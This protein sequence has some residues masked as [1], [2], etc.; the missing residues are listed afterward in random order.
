MRRL[1]AFVVTCLAAVSCMTE[2]LPDDIGND[3]A[4]TTSVVT[5]VPSVAETK[6]SISLLGDAV[7][8]INVYAFRN[9]ILVD[10]VYASLPSDV[11]L[12]LASGCSYDIY[13]VANMGRRRAPASEDVFVE[14]MQY[15]VSKISDMQGPVPMSCFK[16]N[17]QVGLPAQTMTLEMERMV[18]KLVLS[19]EQSA[20]LKG[21]QIRSARLCQ[22]AS[23]VRPFKW[24]GR[25]GSRAESKTETVDGDY[26]TASDLA[27]LNSGGEVVFYALENCQGVLLPD[28][29]DPFLKEPSMI[30]G[31]QD[32]CTYLE[33][34][35]AF[36]GTGLLGGDVSYR[37]YAGLDD[38]TSFDVPGNACINVK[39]SLTDDGLKAVSWKVDADVYVMEGYARGTVVQGMHGMSE[40]YVGEMVKYQVELS[41]ELLEYIDADVLGCSL[42]FVSSGQISPGLKCTN[43]SAQGCL[44]NVEILCE[45]P[46]SGKLCLYSPDGAPVGVLESAVTVNVPG[47]AVTEYATWL[48]E[49]P[50]ETLTY[51][52]ECEVN[53]SSQKLYV[54]FVDKDGRNLNGC[55]AYGFDNSLFRLRYDGAYASSASNGTSSSGGSGGSGISSD[56][57]PAV[58]GSFALIPGKPGSAAASLTVSCLNDGTDHGG[59]ILLTEIY[60]REK[61]LRLKAS[62]ANWSIS[63]E[64][65]M[66]LGIRPVE[67]ELVDNGWAGYHDTQLSMTV[68]N[69]SNLPLDVSV[70]QLVSTNLAA[71]P[72]DSDYVENNLQLDQIPYMTGAH[73]NGD[74]PFYG[75]SAGFHSERNSMGDEALNLGSKLAFPLTGISTNDIRKAIAYGRKGAGQMMHMVDV[76]MAGRPMLKDDLVLYDKVSDGSGTYD[77]IYYSQDS[78][79]YRGAS[80][81]SDG[82][83]VTSSGKWA[84]DYP[85]ATPLALDR[86]CKRY[87]EDGLTCVEL[88]YASGYDRLSVCTYTGMGSQYGLTLKFAY[89]GTV[90]GYVKTYPNGT[91]SSAQENYCY[92]DLAHEVSGVP[93]RL[94]GQ[95]VWADEGQLKAAMDDVYANSYKDSDRP[96]GANAYMHRAHPVE[97]DIDVKLLVEGEKG[98]ELYPYYVRWEEDQI[99]YYHLQDDVTYKCA[100]NAA[101]SG[102]S[103]TLVKHK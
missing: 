20:L 87:E 9:G 53:G 28:N 88:M 75:S 3:S 13:S 35:C 70:W 77:Y 33:I 52:P 82:V 47:M 65:Q 85:N 4:P 39:L 73:Y 38:C 91:W 36:D 10:E 78:W 2:I 26:A 31:K 89:E 1:S 8:N 80:L 100:V 5:F 16:A 74:P 84:Y 72:V 43:L 58:R 34:L 24:V 79:N 30:E 21:L 41:D 11:Q 60:A 49:D 18:A 102:Y 12:E 86:M 96:L 62:E 14:S 51:V 90:T 6:S 71:G 103:M 25:G 92:V 54:Y 83:F 98:A 61:M 7:Q 69:M 94:G 48:D 46:V 44:L 76:T 15:A 99:G 27:L 40:L 64:F 66:D 101:S 45:E 68:M 22:S 42:E 59:N 95:F 29:D 67:L 56:S 63:S 93:L 23:V 37:I 19:V 57:V 55:N 97:M 32:V 17:V 50:V 81:Y